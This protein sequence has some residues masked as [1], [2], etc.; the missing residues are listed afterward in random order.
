MDL[1]DSLSPVT[2]F[3]IAITA[4]TSV[5][6]FSNHNLFNRFAFYPY[7]MWN[8]GEWYRLVTG[9]LIHADLGHLFFNMFALF[10]F[11]PV[12]DSAF[13][14]V[15]GNWGHTFY[16]GM[17]LLAIVTADTFNLFRKSSDP[18]YRSIGASGGV[19]AVVFS[20]I[21]FNPY[22]RI[23]IYFIPI[24]IPAYIFGV[25]YLLYCVY[26]GKRGGDNIGHTAHFTGSLIGFVLPVIFHPWLLT[27]FI[28]LIASGE[29]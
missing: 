19:S 17:Y 18:A 28:S 4:L 26:M 3:I 20:F 29:N 1:I 2:L 7:R 16:A 15:F 21:L 22:G 12:V 6:A 5:V 9:G 10:S 13:V 8:N 11:G 23:A 24:G 27:R 25:L 14:Q